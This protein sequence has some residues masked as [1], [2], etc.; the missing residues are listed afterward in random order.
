[1]LLRCSS[2]PM[3]NSSSCNNMLFIS[4]MKQR[5]C[6]I[7]VASCSSCTSLRQ[8]LFMF[9]SSHTLK[10]ST[11]GGGDKSIP[12]HPTQRL[13]DDE[14]LSAEKIRNFVVKPYVAS[15]YYRLGQTTATVLVLSCT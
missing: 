4:C 5:W 13:D 15:T 6:P 1:M 12:L 8:P 9:I 3:T 14:L 2:K 10:V 7:K 11:L